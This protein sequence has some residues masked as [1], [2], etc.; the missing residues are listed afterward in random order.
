MIGPYRPL[1]RSAYAHNYAHMVPIRKMA[2]PASPRRATNLS[3]DS[4]VLEKARAMD[5]NISRAAEDGVRRAIS[6]EEAKR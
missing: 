4:E 2:M 1:R 3:L 5:I 6:R